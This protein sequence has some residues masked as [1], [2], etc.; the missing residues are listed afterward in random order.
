MKLKR[1][2]AIVVAAA[3]GVSLLLAWVLAAWSRSA[4][5]VGWN[6][7]IQ[8]DDFAFSVL[9]V[10][11]APTLGA[12]DDQ[13]AARGVFYVV[14][15]KVANHARRVNYIFKP[16]SPILLDAS[17]REYVV[18]PQG[19]RAL[20]SAGSSG[21]CAAPIPP[22]SSCMTDVVFDVPADVSDPQ[23]R[24]STGGPLGDL[25]DDMFYGKLRIRLQP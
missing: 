23:V 3:A 12:D 22:G 11:Q 8:Y 9:G 20:D 16:T 7:E 6:Q 14:T 13:Q 15:L 21:G 10:R 18:S 5:V 1:R 4:K 2:T 19:Q 17:G 25:L 24:I